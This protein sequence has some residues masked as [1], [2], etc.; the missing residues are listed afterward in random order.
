MGQGL[1]PAGELGGGSQQLAAP[2]VDGH[3]GHPVPGDL[4]DDRVEQHGG[5]RVAPGHVVEVDHHGGRRVGVVDV[6]PDGQQGL[7]GRGELDVALHGQ[8]PHA[9]V[10]CGD[11]AGHWPIG[12]S[13]PSG[14][15]RT[16][17]GPLRVT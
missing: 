17:D 14:A 15:T 9:V 10:L 4:G 12:H 8:D 6:E 13:D 16:N 1:G 7:L 3:H 5:H 11:P 2:V